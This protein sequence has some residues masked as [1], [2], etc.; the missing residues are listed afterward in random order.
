MS[1]NPH[2]HTPVS[3]WRLLVTML[4]NFAITIAEIIGGI[5]SGSLSL[6]SDA[7]HNFSD[8]LSIVISYAALRLAGRPFSQRHTFGL[9]RAEIFAA[10]INATV[11]VMISLYL[12]YEAV[13]RW[14]HPEP[15]HGQL[16]TI[17]ALIGLTANVV[18]V[19]LLKKDSAGSLNIKS[20]YLH[21]LS[22][23]VSSVG[24]ILGGLAI[25]WWDVFWLDPL[26]TILIGVYI[27]KESLAI[28]REA[29]HVLMEGAPLHITLE[30]VKTAVEALKDVND[31]HH[32]H[33]WTVGENDA[34]L[35]AHINIVDMPV[36]ETTV[37]R[38]RISSILHDQFGIEHVTL[39]FE[40]NQCP[41][42]GLIHSGHHHS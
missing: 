29:F 31:I 30:K 12:F 42:V 8:G 5:M 14:L 18:G 25:Y 23:A 28:L 7:L 16:M 2:H 17:V 13:L 15:V 21:L 26:L 41:N 37:L 1:H 36:S 24:V 9:K 38:Q 3:G 20:A 22:D 4:L 11:L 34:H 40:C 6:I 27:I 35:E 33:A 32:V 39:Q 19:L 10:V